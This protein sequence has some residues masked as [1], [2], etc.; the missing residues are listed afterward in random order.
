MSK[1]SGR[2]TP[3]LLKKIFKFIHSADTIADFK[4]NKADFTRRA[5]LSFPIVVSSILHL[6]KESVEFNLSKI[7]PQ[8]GNRTIG[9][10]AFS[11]ARY[12]IKP[13]FFQALNALVVKHIETLKTNTWKGYQL[14]AVDGSTVSLPPSAQIK[15]AF[16]IFAETANGTKTCMAQALICFDVLSNYVLASRI[17]KMEV[18]E[19]SLLRVLLP[20]IKVTNA[21]FFL[22]RGFG[23]F[24]I[25]K[26]LESHKHKYC[27]RLSTQISSFAKAAM[28]SAK[29]DFIMLWEPSEMER[30][31]CKQHGQDIKAIQVRVSKVLLDSGQTELLVSNLFDTE[32]I[33]ETEIKQLYFMRWGIEEGI[34][35]LKPK[36][37]L[38]HFGCKKIEGIYQEFYAH[39]FML[40]I[41]AILGNEAQQG[42]DLKVKERKHKYKY[43]WQN[44]YRCVRDEIV[45]LITNRNIYKII[46]DLI[47][48]I[49]L[50]IVAIVP[51][52]AFA[53]EKKSSNKSRLFQCYK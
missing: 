35:K 45:S 2:S 52:R 28:M 33:N 21:I 10:A 18:G 30:L 53:R 34:K 46:K 48:K 27:I 5:P 44:A 24:N 3:V 9:G 39:I 25:C 38:E 50:S 20:E 49:A 13:A 17:D 11:A 22:D 16:G 51:D 41:V 29:K 8:F 12:K 32:A 6:F 19:K 42:V 14:I 26:I 1:P 31:S 36:M 23:N 47:K 7:L 37:K 43:N 4:I 15:K 40:N